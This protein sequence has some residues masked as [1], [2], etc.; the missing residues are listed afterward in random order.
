MSA[1]E[2]GGIRVDGGKK[3][4]GTEEA[5]GDTYRTI[6]GVSLGALTG[7]AID[8]FSGHVNGAWDIV[9]ATQTA[10][11]ATNSKQADWITRN[12]RIGIFSS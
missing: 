11:V 1:A 3:R 10:L 5:R 4:G 8:S 9:L 2:A 6:D 12:H 7:R